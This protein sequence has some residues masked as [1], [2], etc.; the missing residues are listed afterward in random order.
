MHTCS[1]C[2]IAVKH[3][4]TQEA[5][6]LAEQYFRVNLV[7]FLLATHLKILSLIFHNSMF[8]PKWKHIMSTAY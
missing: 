1:F 2:P 7:G 4:F 6:S 8:L 5:V 3:S